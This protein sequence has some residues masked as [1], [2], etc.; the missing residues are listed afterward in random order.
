M[1]H[2][3][4]P[5]VCNFSNIQKLRKFEIWSNKWKTHL[6]RKLFFLAHPQQINQHKSADPPSAMEETPKTRLIGDRQP[7]EQNWICKRKWILSAQHRFKRRIDNIVREKQKKKI[8]RNSEGKV[9]ANNNNITGCCSFSSRWVKQLHD[10]K[11]VSQWEGRENAIFCNDLHFA[12]GLK[13]AGG[14]F[15]LASL[16][17][18]L[19]T[20]YFCVYV[21]F[22]LWKLNSFWKRCEIIFWKVLNSVFE[23]C[24]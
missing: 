10:Y 11:G 12:P 4:H 24:F 2:V 17:M 7:T 8:K 19:K 14:F 9:Q 23:D 20:C 15:S 6:K 5:F 13:I 18:H 16:T 21:Q 1:F 3:F 22:K